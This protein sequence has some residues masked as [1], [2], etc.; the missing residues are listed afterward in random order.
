MALSF[1][2]SGAHTCRNSPGQP[3]ACTTVLEENTLWCRGSPAR[4]HPPPHPGMITRMGNR[5]LDFLQHSC[6]NTHIHTLMP[7]THKHALRQCPGSGLGIRPHRN[8]GITVLSKH[9]WGKPLY[10]PLPALSP[11]FLSP[12]FSFFFFIYLIF[13]SLHASPITTYFVLILN[14]RHLLTSI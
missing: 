8:L 7:V 1:S 4:L 9:T 3:C 10:H 12:S 5:A 14:L 13:V 6:T 11:F 2:L